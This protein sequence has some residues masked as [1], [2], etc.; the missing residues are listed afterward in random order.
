M[1]GVDIGD[2]EVLDGYTVMTHA[3][4][5][6]LALEDLLGIHG[7]NGTN[8]ANVAFETVRVTRFQEVVALNGTGKALTFARTCN[9]DLIA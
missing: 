7:T 2:N 5:H 1:I 6:L 9:L 4:S 8:L 3:T